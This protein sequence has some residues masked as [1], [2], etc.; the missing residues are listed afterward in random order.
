MLTDS[1]MRLIDF[2]VK[3]AVKQ[4]VKSCS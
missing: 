3:L 1:D 2:L 4:A